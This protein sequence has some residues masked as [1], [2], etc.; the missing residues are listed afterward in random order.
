M[1]HNDILENFLEDLSKFLFSSLF[2]LTFFPLSPPL[3]KSPQ[4]EPSFNVEPE[5]LRSRLNRLLI[6]QAEYV[7]G[8]K[9][10]KSAGKSFTLSR[11]SFAGRRLLFC[12]SHACPISLSLPVLFKSF[13]ITAKIDA[14]KLSSYSFWYT[15]YSF[16]SY[17]GSLS[18]LS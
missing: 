15:S 5:Y 4:E 10:N 7:G 14:M 12:Y 13:E 6:Q 16:K 1:I 8:E 3:R 11:A 2:H 9:L 18:I 17:I